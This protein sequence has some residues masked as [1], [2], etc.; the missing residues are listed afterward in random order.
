MLQA[1]PF[2]SP[3]QSLS[4]V[5]G[6]DAVR[7]QWVIFSS[8]EMSPSSGSSEAVKIVTIEMKVLFTKPFS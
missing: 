3:F 7:S 6:L 8:G 5:G 4:Q 2:P 1:L